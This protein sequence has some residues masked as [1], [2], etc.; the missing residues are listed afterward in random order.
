MDKENPRW[1]FNGDVRFAF[2]KGCP[3]SGPTYKKLA[4]RIQNRH[5]LKRYNDIC[6]KLD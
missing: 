4:E 3:V 6:E 5:P 2:Y 1:H